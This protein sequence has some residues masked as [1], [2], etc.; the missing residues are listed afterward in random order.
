[1]KYVNSQN[2]KKER[3]EREKE[4]EKKEIDEWQREICKNY[5][6][7]CNNWESEMRPEYYLTAEEYW[8]EFGNSGEFFDQAA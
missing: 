6:M 1:M 7:N 5:D 3:K 4:E 8:E 2:G